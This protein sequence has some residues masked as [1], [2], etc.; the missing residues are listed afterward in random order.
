MRLNDIINE[1]KETYN[2]IDVR[3]FSFYRDNTWNNIFTVIR[4]R[5]ESVDK[6]KQIH[7]ELIRK[8]GGLIETDKY[9]FGLFQF[10][11]SQW[12][13]IQSDF[14]KKF[15]CLQEDYAV[16]FQTIVSLNNIFAE[17]RLDP[18]IEY[19]IKDWKIYHGRIEHSI[20]VPNFGGDLADD[21]LLH[22]FSDID[23]YFSAML[24]INRQ[25]LQH[26]NSIHVIVPVFFKI[27]KIEFD[28]KKF[29]VNFSAATQKNVKMATNFYNTET[30]GTKSEFI[31]RKLIDLEI[32]GDTNMIVD[33]SQSIDIETNSM[34]SEFEI[35]VTKNGIVLDKMR[36]PIGN[37][38]PGRAE[39]TN[40]MYSIFEKFVSHENL[41]KML[42]EYTSEKN[43]LKDESKVF[44]RGVAWLLN[45]LGFPSIF[46][47][48]YEKTGSGS[49]SISTDIISS[50][51]KTIFLVNVTTGLPKASDFD[52]ER[53]YRE[54]ISKLIKNPE[55]KIVSLYFT[56]REATESAQAAQNNDVIL[57][58]KEK[59]K[60][61]LD[62]LKKG[63]IDQARNFILDSGF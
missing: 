63:E 24:Q 9:R 62:F 2:S 27:S 19:V 15:I 21:A 14:S 34:G 13:K 12:E 56:G 43:D 57:V 55:L 25:L 51:E 52:R 41:E 29:E 20:S 18:N 10:P 44:E 23:D 38:W 53:G 61:I 33:N 26:R 32:K 40:P 54:N 22:H 49:N 60:I 8:C 11:I 50:K 1:L 35:L 3:V 42:F 39:F 6:L 28:E 46:L 48:S 7:D 58:G 47:G 30:F 16:N 31:D 37:F 17:P 4:F 59:L 36:E 45:L 5:R